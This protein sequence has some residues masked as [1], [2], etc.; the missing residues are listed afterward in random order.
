MLEEGMVLSWNEEYGDGKILTNA[1][2]FLATSAVIEPD[3]T[4]KRYLEPNEPVF[5]ERASR[6]P[7]DRR[8][9]RV[10][11]PWRNLGDAQ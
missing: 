11:R 8:C 9:I 3:V 5:V 6:D 4:G 2:T 10:E 7:R 1:G